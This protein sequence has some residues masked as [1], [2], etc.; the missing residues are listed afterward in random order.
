MRALLV[1]KD[2][3]LVTLLIIN[4]MNSAVINYRVFEGPSG[5]QSCQF[6][7]RTSSV[8]AVHKPGFNLSN[9]I[10]PVTHSQNVTGHISFDM[11]I[12]PHWATASSIMICD[13]GVS[14]IGSKTGAVWGAHSKAW[15]AGCAV[16]RHGCGGGHFPAPAEHPACRSTGIRGLHAARAIAKARLHGWC[17]KFSFSPGNRA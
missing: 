9:N 10:H 3:G 15:Q 17:V 13:V 6:H 12:Q 1:R 8:Y 4:V 14:L 5:S 2:R 16:S 11:P 7:V